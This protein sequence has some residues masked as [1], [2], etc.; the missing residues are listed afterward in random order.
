MAPVNLTTFGE[1]LERCSL[2]P[3][4]C[5]YY[6]HTSG[7]VYHSLFSC[8]DMTFSGVTKCLPPGYLVEKKIINSVVIGSMPKYGYN[9]KLCISISERI[10]GIEEESQK[11]LHDK[12]E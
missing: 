5:G 1:W 10:S 4:Q 11:F 8:S 7:G 2:L 9:N 12:N 3:D 6:T